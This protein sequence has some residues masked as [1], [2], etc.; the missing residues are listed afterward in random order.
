MAVGSS[1]GLA[2][3]DGMLVSQVDVGLLLVS[4]MLLGLLV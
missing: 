4:V 2:A 1:S 3:S